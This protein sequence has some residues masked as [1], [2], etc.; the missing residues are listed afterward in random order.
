LV[1]VKN[2][3]H[4]NYASDKKFKEFPMLLNNVKDFIDKNP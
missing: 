4:F 3:G 1:V 2:A